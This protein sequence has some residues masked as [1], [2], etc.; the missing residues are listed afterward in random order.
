MPNT[1]SQKAT[2]IRN[3]KRRERNRG[4]RSEMRTW[5]KSTLAAI[6]EGNLE[7]AQAAFVQAT[8]HIDKNVKWNQLH[9]N[10]GAHRKSQLAKA[11]NALK[12]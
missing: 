11:V 8:K 3:A 4:R 7:T 2:L 12:A 10:A 5:I 6:E 1:P 9:A